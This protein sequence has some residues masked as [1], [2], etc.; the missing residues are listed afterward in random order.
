MQCLL[1][2]HP[3]N[4]SHILSTDTSQ[5][6]LASVPGSLLLRREPGNKAKTHHTHQRHTHTHTT[7]THTVPQTHTI[8]LVHPHRLEKS[9][10]AFMEIFLFPN[11]DSILKLSL[12]VVDLSSISG[13]AS[14]KTCPFGNIIVTSLLK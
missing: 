9:L 7:D 4:S 14:V 2:D 1:G 11:M 5:T 8:S 3:S 13:L 10:S 12:T 6:H